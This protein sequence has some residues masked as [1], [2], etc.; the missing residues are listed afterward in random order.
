MLL[1]NSGGGSLMAL[2]QARRAPTVAARR[3]LRRP[4]RPSRRGRLHA[5]GHRPV[6]HRRGRPLLGRPLPRHV[7]PRQR[8]AAV[9]RAVELRP[10]L[11]R[12]LP[13]GAAGTGR[14]DRRDRRAPPSTTARRGARRRARSSTAG[15]TRGATPGTVPCTPA[16]SRSTG[17]SPTPPTS[18][19]P[20][21]P[22][23]GALGI[24]LRLPRPDGRQ[25][26]LRRPRSGD[27]GA[28]VAVDVV[29]AVE[30]DAA[31]ADTLPGGRRPDRCS[32]T[33]PATPRSGCGR[34]AAVHEASGAADKTYV[35]VAK[36]GALPPR[37]PAGGDDHGRRLAPVAGAVSEPAGQA[38]ERRVRT[39]DRPIIGWREWVGAARARRRVGEGQ[40]RHRRPVVVAA[41]LGRRRRRGAG[42]RAL[43]RPPVP[44]RR[45]PTVPVDAPR[46]STMRDVRSSNGDVERRPVIATRAVIGGVVV[47]IELTPHQPR[48]DGVPHAA[49]ARRRSAGGSSSTPGARSSAAATRQSPPPSVCAAVATPPHEDRHPLPRRRPSTRPPASGRRPRRAATRRRSSTTCAAT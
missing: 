39:R 32:C 5:P 9:A 38:K 33:R 36:A 37:P 14:S 28:R 42:R 4:R 21:T 23:T 40:G 29:G 27:D 16:T 12:P 49:R 13:G 10:R 3:R 15:P 43:R 25:L 41:R 45:R 7:R 31:M 2:A 8:V 48:R 30:L 20:S 1:G 34:R 44:A 11:G 26:R 18:T 24:D 6:G 19:R 47:P 35:E 46:W 17:P 22:T